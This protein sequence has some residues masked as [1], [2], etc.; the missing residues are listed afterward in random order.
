MP[1]QGR[2]QG[3]SGGNR[4]GAGRP[5]LPVAERHDAAF[6]IRMRPAEVEALRRLAETKG[7]GVGTY[8]RNV[9]RAHLERR[10]GSA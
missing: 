3:A 5:P 10:G 8:A 2:K 9:L 4:Q 1:K 7:V 6:L